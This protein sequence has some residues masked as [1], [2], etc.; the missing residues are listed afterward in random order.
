M[1]GSKYMSN[2]K[3]AGLTQEDLEY[4]PKRGNEQTFDEFAALIAIGQISIDQIAPSP[5]DT[6]S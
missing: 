5:D 1:K 3:E 2:P 4:L 6:Q